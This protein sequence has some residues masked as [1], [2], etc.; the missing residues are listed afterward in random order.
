MAVNQQQQ[1]TA[2]RSL[3]WAILGAAALAAFKTTPPEVVQAERIELVTR[4]GLRQAQLAADS[5]GLTITLFDRRGRETAS[6]RFDDEPR[7]AVL[8]Q[9]RQEVVGLGPPRPQHLAQ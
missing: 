6:F 5:V 2:A 8:N 7:L 3:L 9:S 4:E 1:W